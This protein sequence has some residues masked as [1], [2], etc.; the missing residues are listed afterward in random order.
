MSRYDHIENW[1]DWVVHPIYTQYAFSKYGEIISLYGNSKRRQFKL[2]KGSLNNGYIMLDFIHNGKRVIP[3]V[4][5]LIIEAFIGEI[6]E[7]YVVNHKDLNRS[8][9]SLSN[10]EAIT[11][12]DNARHAFASNAIHHANGIDN[13]NSLLTEIEVI[14]I[15]SKYIPRKYSQYKLADEY[16]VSQSV[17]KNV[18]NN[19]TYIL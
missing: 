16:N 19:K 8:N 17:I 13:H 5:R 3:R 14:E 9:N 4:H 15:R 12:A 1:D 7:G 2:I 11:Q 10:L 6:P 18:V